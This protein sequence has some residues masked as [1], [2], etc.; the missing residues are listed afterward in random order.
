MDVNDT[1][2]LDATELL[3]AYAAGSYSP[4]QVLQGV[5]ERIARRNPEINAFAAMNPAALTAARQSTL[6]WREGKARALEGVPVTVC[7]F[8]DVAGL[9]TRRGSKTTDSA[10]CRRDSPHIA[11]LRAAGAVILGK[12]T[13]SE[14]GWSHLGG[15]PLNGMIRNPWNTSHTAGGPAGGAAAAAAG[16]FGPLHIADGDVCIPA[17]WTGVVGLKIGTMSE[18]QG[19]I[20]RS[21]EDVALLSALLKGHPRV[22]QPQPGVAGLKI[23]ILRTPGFAAPASL[24]AWETVQAAVESLTA[25]GAELY[26]IA[27]DLPAIDRVYT[28]MWSRERVKTVAALSVAQQSLLTPELLALAEQLGPLS[29]AENQSLDAACA[30]SKARMATLGVDAILCPTVPHGAPLVDSPMPD[31]LVALMQDWAPWTMLF[32]LTGQ[33]ALTL[34]MGVDA[35]GL[36][37]SVQIAAGQEGEDIIL[38]IAKALEQ[39]LG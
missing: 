10:P 12:T 28:A 24:T 11:V 23:G 31:P 22:A 35:E 30:E 7:D 20:A 29:E 26:D 38:R 9:P 15:S 13:V 2:L 19:I 1:A 14:F 34:P 5:T 33:P 27:P 6:R 25:Q 4:L 16:F 36:P 21:V 3:H 8:V 18:N 17:S 37:T 32:R 39:G